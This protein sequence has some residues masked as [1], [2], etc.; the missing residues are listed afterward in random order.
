MMKINSHTLGLW[1]LRIGLAGTYLYSSLGLLQHPDYW[2]QFMPA[3][4]AHLLPISP[5]L[6][7]QIQG[8][9]EL[10]FIL[11]LLTGVAMHW[12]ALLSAGEMASILLFYGLDGI[13]FRDVAIL[14]AA[15]GLFFLT[16]PSREK[17]NLRSTENTL[18]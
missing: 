4:F 11:S 2:Y 1:C 15:L 9:M 12:T 16:A 18:G 13:S 5:L 10:L 3:W 6:Y 7:L 14:G 17:E 8:V